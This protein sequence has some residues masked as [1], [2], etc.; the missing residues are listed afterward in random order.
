[1]SRAAHESTVKELTTCYTKNAADNKVI[2]SLE[3]DIAAKQATIDE[4][5]RN[6][7]TVDNALLEEKAASHKLKTECDKALTE[8]MLQ[9]ADVVGERDAER[10]AH[11]KTCGILDDAWTANRELQS[12]VEA[13]SCG[14][15][16]YAERLRVTDRATNERIVALTRERDDLGTALA[17]ESEALTD[18]RETIRQ[19]NMAKGNLKRSKEANERKDADIKELKGKLLAGQTQLTAAQKGNDRLS[20]ENAKLKG[21]VEA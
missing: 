13:V 12:Q 19:S 5:L 17:A 16:D 7:A 10:E 21:N 14:R 9:I 1:M 2:R 4:A 6:L 20:K 15:D 3:S 8:I 18:A 11:K